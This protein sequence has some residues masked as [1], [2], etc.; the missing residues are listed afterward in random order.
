[1]KTVSLIL[2]L[3][4]TAPVWSLCPM[5]RRA[6]EDP[7]AFEG[8]LHETESPKEKRQ[9]GPA[10]L[11]FTSFNENQE[12]DVSGLH[13]WIAPGPND[14]RGPCP[15]LNALANHGYFPRNGVV[16]LQQA[17]TATRLV[18]GQWSIMPPLQDIAA[19]ILS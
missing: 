6:L 14:I 16:P 13:R 2:G 1:M 4:A 3:A 18:Y 10:G 11:P 15:G 8:L 17:A 7:A 5:A 19:L 9:T 12:I